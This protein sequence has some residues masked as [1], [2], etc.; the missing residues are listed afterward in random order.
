MTGGS[1]ALAVVAPGKSGK[2]ELVRRIHEAPDQGLMPPAKT[3]R[4]LSAEQKEL[5]RR[6]IDEGAV[7]GKH[8]AYETPLRPDVPVVKNTTWVRNPIDNFVLARLTKEGL[9]PSPEAGKETLIRRVSL[10]LTGLPPTPREVDAFLADR[11]PDAYEKLVDR[12]L[13]SPRYGE[14]MAMEW[15]DEARYADTNGYQNDFARTMWPWR[16]WVIE[17]FNRNQPFDRFVIDQIAGDLL[18]NATLAQKI[19]TGFNRNNRTVTE[20]GSIDEEWR[21]ENA[22]DRVETTATV[23]LGLTMGCGRCH[24]HKY[25]PISQKEFY[26]FFGFFNSVNER[27]VYTEQRGNVPPLVTVAA[28]EDEERL[29]KLAEASAAAERALR[30]QEAGLAQRQ[31]QWEKEEQTRPAPLEPR[32]WAWRC[33]LDGNLKSQGQDGKAGAADYKGS[34]PPAWSDASTGMA[35]KLDGKD[36]SFVDAGQAVALDRTERFSYGCW[37]RAGSKGAL[38]S[39]MDENAGFRGFDLLLVNGK[40][41]VHLVHAWPGNALKVATQEPIPQEGWVQVLF[42]HDGSG[43]AAGVKLYVNGRPVKL[44]VASDTLRGTILTDQPLRIGKRSASASLTGEVADVRVY[45]RALAAAEAQAL[46][47]QLVHAILETPAG[48]RSRA[49]QD[50]LAQV[51]RDHFAAQ[52]GQ[53]KDKVARLRKDRAEFEKRLPTVMV[54]EDVKTPRETYVLKRGRYDMPDKVQKVEPGTPASLPAM[55]PGA[56]RNRLGLAQWLVSPDNPLTARVRVNHFWQKS[57]GNG[58][59]KTAENFGIQGSL[60]SH[61]D[62]LDYLAT[63]FVRGGWDVKA[64]RRLIVT[65]ATYRQ[66]SRATAALVQ[67][68]PDNRLLAQGRVSGCRPRLCATTLWR[69]AA[70]FMRRSAARP[71]SHISPW[72][73]GK[74]W[75]AAPA[76]G[77][78][79]RKKGPVST[80]AASTFTASGPCRTRS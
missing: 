69:S 49:R 47:T 60:P 20:A 37:V 30:E 70:C 2:S 15:L 64:L 13:A 43:K 42:T 9:T 18:P 29:H 67:R 52:L 66:S 58:L 25:D 19:A 35:L 57:F 31:Q 76:R 73:C 55:P 61:P 40:V 27:G 11:S 63:E 71:S 65:S 74:H 68:D 17:A 1:S 12:L 14:A 53:A 79:S 22:I 36:S 23:F 46:V 3:N 32:D 6:W 62:L 48:K 24:D 38:L 33:S 45:R 28:R 8:W 4:R 56:P 78:M 51:F 26:Q 50:L 59:V 77:P 34:G 75:P 21:V 72:G 7:W 54:M 44:A 39:K 10:D 16:D 80:A 41:E 5:L